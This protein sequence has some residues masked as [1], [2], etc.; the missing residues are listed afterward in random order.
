MLATNFQ[1]IRSVYG[2]KHYMSQG[3]SP[4]IFGLVHSYDTHA[5]QG[6]SQQNKH[7][8]R[9]SSKKEHYL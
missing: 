8:R 2:D 5:S 4:Q 9:H 3:N 7:N 6:Q 1:L